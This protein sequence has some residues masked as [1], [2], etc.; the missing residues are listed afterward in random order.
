MPPLSIASFP[1]S[2]MLG[3][4]IGHDG[5]PNRGVAISASDPM[6]LTAIHRPGV[7]LAICHRPLP[8]ALS[9]SALRRLLAAAPFTLTATG[10]PDELPDRIAARAPSP[11]PA[12]LMFDLA[13]LAEL[14]G[15]LDDRR[16][17]VRVRLEALVH[18]GC[19]K[20]HADTVGLRLLCT[21][22]GAGTQWLSMDGGAQVARS[23]Q[24]P[25]P[26]CAIRQIPAGAIAIL[27][28][29]CYPDNA[30]NGCIH[31]S[32]PAGPGRRA[33]LLLCVDQPDWNLD[34]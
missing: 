17:R 31:R 30:G 7:H 29:E 3:A 5:M 15:I 10:T 19:R 26:P 4:D 28:G 18:D 16:E 6:V 1:A 11:V 25:P 34:E 9:G 27:K 14:F 13:D 24:T 21:Y 22:R 2:A 12:A 20:W 8:R 23:M 32:P 33:R